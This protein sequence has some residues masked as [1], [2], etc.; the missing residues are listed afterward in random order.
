MMSEQQKRRSAKNTVGELSEFN[1]AA[2]GQSAE[3]V[4]E[5]SDPTAEGRADRNEVYVSPVIMERWKDGAGNEYSDLITHV[6]FVNHPVDHSQGPFKKLPEVQPGSVALA[7]RMGL[8]APCVRMGD[9]ENPFAKKDGDGD[10]KADEG[11]APPAEDKNE[12]MPDGSQSGKEKQLEALLAHLRNDGYGLPSDTDS[13]NFIE[14][15]LTASLTKQAVQQKADAEAA[16][17]KD[18]EEDDQQGD[19]TVADPGYAAMSLYA[20]NMH[21]DSIK[22]KLQTLLEQGRC[23]PDEASQYVEALTAVKLSLDPTGKQLGKSDVEVFIAHRE[24]VPLGTFWDDKTRTKKMSAS[25]LEPGDKMK[26]D[27]SEEDAEKIVDQ[28]FGKKPAAA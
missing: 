16:A 14:R 23:K 9:D 6:D 25:V 27:P 21:R 20:E 1:L 10:G 24:A 19:V 22:A 7:I 11:D 28:M 18:D 12:D 3:L 13:G 17:D 4:L 8:T 5:V 26:F 2:D 15:M